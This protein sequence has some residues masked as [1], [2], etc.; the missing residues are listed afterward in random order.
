[1]QR[2][3]RLRRLPLARENLRSEIGKARLHS[4]IG[5]R[6]HGGGIELGDDVLWRILWRETREPAGNESSG[7]A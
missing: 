4:R 1:V 3:E 2:T 7:V 5:Q 6:L